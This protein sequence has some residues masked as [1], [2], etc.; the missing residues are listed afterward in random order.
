MQDG[1]LN[2]FWWLSW[3]APLVIMF[4]A[5]ATRNR[6]IFWLGV[7][8]S[9]VVTYILCVQA[10]EAKWIMRNSTASSERD[11]EFANA[12]GANLVFT[13]LFLAP[14]QAIFFT[15]LWSKIGRRIWQRKSVN[16]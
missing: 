10:T 1:T 7:V 11:I 6:A 16:S 2:S 4:V 9:I 14:F 5:C 3:I 13:A 12:D 8:S 15:W